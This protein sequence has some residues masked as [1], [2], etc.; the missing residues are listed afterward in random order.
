MLGDSWNYPG[1]TDILRTISNGS[2]HEADDLKVLEELKLRTDAGFDALAATDFLAEE[3][4]RCTVNAHTSKL[5]LASSTPLYNITA[6]SMEHTQPALPPSSL[7]QVSFEPHDADL[8]AFDARQHR[9]L[10]AA[11]GVNVADDLDST[12]S[13]NSDFHASPDTPSHLSFPLTPHSAAFL[14][15][16]HHI[17]APPQLPVHASDT[18]LFPA[19]LNPLQSSCSSDTHAAADLPPLEI[20]AA[21]NAATD[22]LGGLSPL[23]QMRHELGSRSGTQPMA[24]DRAWEVTKLL[25]SCSN[26]HMPSF[27]PQE[28]AVSLARPQ[29]TGM[30]TASGR[31]SR[32][33]SSASSFPQLSSAHSF[34][35]SS[36]LMGSSGQV[37]SPSRPLAK[38]TRS[39][40]LDSSPSSGADRLALAR[41]NTPEISATDTDD[42]TSGDGPHKRRKGS[43]RMSC[44]QCGTHNTPQWRMG[45]EGPRTLCN[46]CGVRFT[47]IRKHGGDTSEAFPVKR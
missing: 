21:F 43:K 29:Q 15:Q 11:L 37:R 24:L 40:Q 44:R 45:P 46:A 3:T 1:S 27:L 31:L 10:L 36:S 33:P 8:G 28:L 5:L 38:R 2:A 17:Q 9:S 39:P 6:D 4:A 14:S 25:E 16:T 34:P 42:S 23:S 35:R 13:A 18:T 32:A 20:P 47:K 7:A 22:F 41:K 12:K 19:G 26:P 30:H